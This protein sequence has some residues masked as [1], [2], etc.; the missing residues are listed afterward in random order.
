MNFRDKEAFVILYD[1]QSE[2]QVERLE[3]WVLQVIQNSS[4]EC[5]VILLL[6]HNAKDIDSPLVNQSLQEIVQSNNPHRFLL[7]Q[8]NLQTGTRVKESFTRLAT[9]L[10]QQTQDFINTLA[11][12][13]H[14]S[15]GSHAL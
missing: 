4:Y 10:D 5:S 7:C 3:K 12:R 6:G 15:E 14:I 2:F 11:C 9:K 13:A 8:C 1:A